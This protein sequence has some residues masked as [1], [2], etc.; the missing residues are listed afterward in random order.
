M[1]AAKCSNI[2]VFAPIVVVIGNAD[3]DAVNIN[4]ES[5]AFGDVGESAVVIIAIESGGGM[6]AFWN[7]IFAIDD[8]NV[9][10][11]I[12]IGVE[13]RAAGTHGFG[14]PFFP[15]ATGVVREL[16]AG[17]GGNIREMNRV[18]GV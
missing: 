6:A 1:I 5:A 15:A 18:R 17:C 3:A 7:Q 13:E 9:E 16:D 4:I 14:Q 2:N 8:Q 12:A 10:P 11:A